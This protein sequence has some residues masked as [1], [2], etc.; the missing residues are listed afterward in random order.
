MP[1]IIYIIGT[2]KGLSLNRR[3]SRRVPIN[4]IVY[5]IAKY[6][7]LFDKKGRII[8]TADAV[9]FSAEN[10]SKAVEFLTEDLPNIFYE[11]MVRPY[12][13]ETNDEGVYIEVHNRGVGER[14]N[15]IG[16]KDK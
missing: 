13:Q 7:L 14:S 5:E 8:L 6:F 9:E 10:L 16:E 4:I 1:V 3:K 15:A 11:N 12:A 2:A